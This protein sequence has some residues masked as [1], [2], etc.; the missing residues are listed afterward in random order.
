MPSAARRPDTP[1]CARRGLDKQPVVA[2]GYGDRALATRQQVLDPFPLVVPQGI[3]AHRSASIKLT[4][5]ESNQISNQERKY[6][7]HA[8]PDR[9]GD[10]TTGQDPDGRRE[11]I[12]LVHRR[13]FLHGA[14]SPQAFHARRLEVDQLAELPVSVRGG[15]GD[16]GRDHRPC[17]LRWSCDTSPVTERRSND[18][19]DMQ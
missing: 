5:Q 19:R 8:G 3:A 4:A 13:V 17:R 12:I 6:Q 14:D 7:S 18:R 16:S 2:G 1:A 9:S 15:G 10:H 11:I